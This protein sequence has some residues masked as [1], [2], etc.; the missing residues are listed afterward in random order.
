MKTHHGDETVLEELRQ[1]NFWICWLTKSV[2]FFG[3]FLEPFIWRCRN[4]VLRFTLWQQ[5]CYEHRWRALAQ[6]QKHRLQTRCERSGPWSWNLLDICHLKTEDPWN[7]DQ[8]KMKDKCGDKRQTSNACRDIVGF[9]LQLAY[10]CIMSYLS[11]FEFQFWGFRNDGRATCLHHR[12][13]GWGSAKRVAHRQQPVPARA[14]CSNVRCRARVR[15][16]GKV[17][18]HRT[19]DGWNRGS[20]VLRKHL[21]ILSFI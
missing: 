5:N 8:N 11:N 1:H 16:P 2:G 17:L 19:T 3:I 4:K 7:T 6:Y 13:P 15:Q 18:K 21:P 9:Q 20:C 10:P 14:P 12:Q